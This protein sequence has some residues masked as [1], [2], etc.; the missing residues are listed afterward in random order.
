MFRAL[1]IVASLVGASAFAPTSSRVASSSLRMSDFENEVGVLKPTGFWDPLGL[2]E[3]I[4]QETFDRYRTAE[5]KHGRVAQLA[6]VG[7]LVPELIG[8]FPGSVGYPG[9]EVN[10]ADIPNGVDALT[11]LPSFGS[12]QI[13]A[14]IGF[15]ELFGWKETGDSIGDFGLGAQYLNDA[16]FEEKKTKELQNGRLAM[17]AAAELLT[18]D[19]ATHGTGESLLTLHHF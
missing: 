5:L 9:M 6:V 11:V 13:A 17:L 18:H 19:I 14:S 1:M 3:G 8:K 10:F 2:S 7:Y 16:N 4:D 15:W 12:F